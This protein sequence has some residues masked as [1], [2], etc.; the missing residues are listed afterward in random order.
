MKF[1]SIQST[2][3]PEITKS[4]KECINLGQWLLFKA[5]QQDE[6]VFF[7][8]KVGTEIYPLSQRG[9]FL[10]STPVG[11][12]EIDEVYYFS[13]MPKPISLSNASSDVYWV[14]A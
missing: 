8:L 6:N 9:G 3:L 2:A 11:N 10:T 5:E 4:V 12:V 1:V 14:S 13:D 7:Y